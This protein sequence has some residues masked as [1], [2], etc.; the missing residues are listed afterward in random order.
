MAKQKE[1][2]LKKLFALSKIFTIVYNR[3]TWVFTFALFLIMLIV[4]LFYHPLFIIGVVLLLIHVFF[5]III[6]KCPLCK[7]WLAGIEQSRIYHDKYHMQFRISY[8]CQF[9]GHE[10]NREIDTTPMG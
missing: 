8:K 5:D 10:W 6:L 2:I 1:S 9:C 4:A 3:Q 7:K